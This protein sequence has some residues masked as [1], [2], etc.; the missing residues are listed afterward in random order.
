ML[1]LLVLA[2]ALLGGSVLQAN[3]IQERARRFTRPVEFNFVRWTLDALWG[4]WEMLSVGG[5]LFLPPDARAAVVEDYLSAVAESRK[6]ETD[7]REA[8]SNPEEALD[9]D[10]LRELR[11]HFQAATT[12]K[13]TLAPWAEA[14]LESQ[15]SAVLYRNGLTLGGQPIP[16]VSF[17]LTRPP[18]ALIVSPRE[19]IRQEADISLQP[20]LSP[21]A[22]QNLETEVEK[23]LNVSALVVRT[24]GIGVY[25]TMVL[26]STDLNWVCE[27]VAHEWTHNYLDW[28]P[29][30]I[31]YGASPEMRTINETVATISGQENGGL[32]IKTYYPERVPP[33]A[34]PPQA[35]EETQNAPP[36]FDFQRE[37]HRTRMA[38]DRLLAEGA[39]ERA[40]WYMEV[41]RRFFWAHGY[42][43]RKLNQAYF[44]F[45][46]AYAAAPEGA[47]GEDPVGAAVR[48]MRKKSPSVGAFV[49][50][51]AWVVSWRQLE[52]MAGD[53]P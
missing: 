44:A 26:E 30:G 41:R 5:A 4:K 29:L 47:A 33:P 50:R 49:R 28:H 51:M 21:D 52:A 20:R 23:T 11:T 53:G 6:A 37:M 17:H 1:T 36:A 13:E 25:P 19:V 8:L 2:G 38:V 15:V 7:L 24:G 43:L 16:P 46:G 3:S 27:V 22:V 39:V 34:P 10:T 12:Q 48:L 31:R 32:V 35:S 14:V 18:Q 40:E 42:H 9:E 45:Y